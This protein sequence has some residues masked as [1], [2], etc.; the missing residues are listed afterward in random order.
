MILV[1]I[2]SLAYYIYLSYNEYKVQCVRLRVPHAQFPEIPCN[3]N[4][5]MITIVNS[6]F[7]TLCILLNCMHI[8]HFASLFFL[9]SL[10]KDVLYEYL[11]VME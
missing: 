7:S 1:L 3:V 4:F 5:S 10:N 8:V 9:S 6:I 2:F 11:T